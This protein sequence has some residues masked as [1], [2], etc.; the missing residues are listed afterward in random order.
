M[1]GNEAKKLCPEIRLFR[2]PEKRGKA[3]LDKYRESCREVMDIFLQKVPSLE[4]ASVDEAFLDITD[5]VHE[6]IL[7]GQTKNLDLFQELRD[8]TLVAHYDPEDASH[9]SHG[10][11]CDTLL[12]DDFDDMWSETDDHTNSD[13]EEKDDEFFFRDATSDGV[14]CQLEGTLPN[15]QLDLASE[16]EDEGE[17]ALVSGD[18]ESSQE[19]RKEALKVWLS[20]EGQQH[21]LHLAVGAV[22]AK[23]LRKAVYDKLGF[24]CS[25][26]ISHN[27][28]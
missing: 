17:E 8:D 14:S 22:V 1:S 20:R 6:R 27:K 13:V 19:K 4:R 15:D 23:E 10:N 26:G 7:T 5:I 9:D 21:D 28:V 11:Q 3:N 12:H 24:T 18:V 25:A 2:I 16:T